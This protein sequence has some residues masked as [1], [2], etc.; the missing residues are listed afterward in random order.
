[1]ARDI[2]AYWSSLMSLMS[3]P[4]EAAASC[5]AGAALPSPVTVSVP[6]MPESACPGMVHSRS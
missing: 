6:V 4:P 2:S 3:R 1:M 5:P